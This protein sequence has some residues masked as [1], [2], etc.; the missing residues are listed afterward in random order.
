MSEFN[1][2]YAIVV[3][4]TH[5]ALCIPVEILVF[6]GGH[7]C[8]LAAWFSCFA[9]HEKFTGVHHSFAFPM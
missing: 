4:C 5:R 2:F 3:A 1:L 7:P 6:G 9:A 8:Q